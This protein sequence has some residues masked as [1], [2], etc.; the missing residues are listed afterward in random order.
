MPHFIKQVEGI[1]N[2]WK[3]RCEV[4]DG[5]QRGA[6]RSSQ[7]GG[8]R[9]EMPFPCVCRHRLHE[10]LPAIFDSRGTNARRRRRWLLPFGM[11]SELEDEVDGRWW[12]GA[13]HVHKPLLPA[14]RVVHSPVTTPLPAGGAAAAADSRPPVRE[15]GGRAAGGA[16]EQR[17]SGWGCGGGGA[18]PPSAAPQPGTASSAAT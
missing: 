4:G 13:V 7:A 1:V 16:W 6:Y 10:K 14:P 11:W 2:P 8:G 15:A 18:A 17:S 9:L 12:C 5:R 3:H